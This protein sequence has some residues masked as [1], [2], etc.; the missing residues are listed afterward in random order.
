MTSLSRPATGSAA[1]RLRHNLP[2]A[3]AQERHA[4]I[5]RRYPAP[6]LLGGGI[7]L[8][9]FLLALLAPYIAP[10]DMAAIAPAERLQAPSWAHPF[11][12]DAFGRDLFSRVVWG[13]RSSLTV[14][15]LAVLI[16]AVP[17][18]LLGVLAGMHP[19][20][21]ENI[22][23]RL[24]DAWIAVPGLLLAVVMASML[25]RSLLVLGLA[26]GLIG[27]PTYYR[28]ARAETLRV[29]GTRYVEAARAVG[30]TRLHIIVQHVLPNVLPCLLILITLRMGG[31]LMAVGAL[32]FIGLGVPPPLPEWG[33]LLA[34]GRGY[35]YQAWW[36]L[37]FP[38]LAIGVAAFGLNLLGDGLRDLLTPGMG[39]R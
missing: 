24:M 19:G 27:I 32:G 10:Y 4:A 17:G 2:S 1:H 3:Q 29:S 25:G 21:G 6:L 20:L 14:A 31:L 9:L 30:G 37:A 33:T 36:L 39:S 28:Q 12:T 26:L 15:G 18:V 35:L 5:R 38:G 8:A 23:T 16:G 7:V 34:E 11:G 13:G 22:L